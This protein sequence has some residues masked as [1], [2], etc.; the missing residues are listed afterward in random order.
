[1]ILTKQFCEVLADI[2]YLAGARRFHSGDSRADVES[3]FNWA[4]EFEALHQGTEWGGGEN[5]YI[6]AIGD[7]A[8]GKLGA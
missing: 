5:D 2:A 8:A 4:M 6:E 3:F 1:M 7:F